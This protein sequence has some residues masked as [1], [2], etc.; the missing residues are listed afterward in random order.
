MSP[1]ERR[2][3]PESPEEPSGGPWLTLVAARKVGRKAIGIEV[4]E[5][6]CEV[7]ANRL[8][9]EVLEV[10]TAERVAVTVAVNQPAVAPE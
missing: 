9:Q 7:A 5:R 1:S 10:A 3:A 6:Y 8:R 4:D 2:G